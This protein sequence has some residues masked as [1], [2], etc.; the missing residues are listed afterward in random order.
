MKNLTTTFFLK[1][2]TVAIGLI[3]S[4]LII[5]CFFRFYPKFIPF[6]TVSQDF[7]TRSDFNNY[8]IDPHFLA[9]NKTK[10]IAIGD[11]ITKGIEAPRGRRWTEL[12]E[13]AVDGHVANFG[14]GGFST[15]NS[16]VH[17]TSS[18]SP[19]NIDAVIHTIYENDIWGIEKELKQFEIHPEKYVNNLVRRLKNDAL[20][21]GSPCYRKPLIKQNNMT[22]WKQ[23]WHNNS[24][25]STFSNIVKMLPYKFNINCFYQYSFAFTAIANIVR[26]YDGTETRHHILATQA[27]KP[28]DD[29]IFE[30][31]SGTWVWKYI[32]S[33]E[34]EKLAKYKN[35]ENFLERYEKAIDL[36]VMFSLEIKE[37]LKN[38]G[39][40]YYVSYI[41][42]RNEIYAPEIATLFK[43][44]LDQKFFIGDIFLS[45]FPDDVLYSDFT[46]IFLEK[47][48]KEQIYIPWD[49]FVSPS[50]ARWP[51]LG[52]VGHEI[53]SEFWSQ[54]LKK[55]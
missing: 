19:M 53:V 16:L 11:S 50:G 3:L 1:I 32:N 42:S 39:V 14:F 41:P 34:N 7:H 44:K 38:R 10:F 29:H 51:H 24:S 28:T 4:V 13:K 27:E 54:K 43:D 45:K 36:V 26:Y 8:L 2:C 37:F 30:E 18:I 23:L 17:L 31:V 33:H 40:K 12:L 9:S 21:Y 47:K 55:Y 20:V 15:I 48:L 52:Q 25:N 6:N 49:P 5:E 35:K 22:S 46:R